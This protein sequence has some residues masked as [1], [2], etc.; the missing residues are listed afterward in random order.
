[1]AFDNERRIVADAGRRMFERKLTV[2]TWGNVSVRA[3][4]RCIITP[5][6]K[7]YLETGPEDMIVVD[8][9]GN[10]I[11]GRWRPSTELAMHCEIY[12]RRE[13]VNAVVHIHP[14]YSSIL[15]VLG[16]GIPPI[17]EDMVMLLGEEVRVSEY[18]LPGTEEIARN[19]AEALGKNNAVILANHGS[20]CVGEDMDRALTACE[21]LEKSAQIYF[22]SRLLGD[23]KVLP[24]DDVMELM[25]KARGYLGQWKQE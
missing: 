3:R 7:S 5:S 19:A 13:D 24:R 23:P 6:G 14:T 4:D 11:E 18:T 21:V 22:Y 12:R 1:M 15:S 20:V 25:R 8:L 10:V 17:M 16:E 9:E 2:G